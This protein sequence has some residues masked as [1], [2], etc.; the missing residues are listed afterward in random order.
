MYEDHLTA[1]LEEL[2]KPALVNMHT[3]LPDPSPAIRD[4]VRSIAETAHRLIVMAE[5][6]VEI[7][8]RDYGITE[9][10]LVIPHGM[11][12]I[13]PKGR[14]RLK[15]KLGLDG[16][17]IISTF[18]L[19][20]PG[21]GL[22]YAIEAMPA[23]AAR[24]PEALY[25]IAGQTHPELLKQRGE[26]YRNRLQTLVD[27]LGLGDH[28]LFVNQYLDQKDIIEYLLATD[29]YVTPY[30]DPNQITSGT[31]SYAL[32]AGKAVVSTPYLHAKEALAKDRG[33]LVDFRSAESIAEAVN[34]I[35]DDPKRKARLEKNAYAYANEA[36]WPRDRRAVPRRDAGAGRRAS[37]G[38]RA[39]ASRA[40]APDRAPS[41][42]EPA[43]Q[44]ERPRA[45]AAGVRGDL[46]DQ[47]GVA[48][49]R[50]RDR[51]ARPGR[52]ASAPRHRTRR[53]RHDDRPVRS[54]A[55]LDAA[56]PRPPAASSWSAWPTS[57]TTGIPRR[58]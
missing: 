33:I 25:L 52:R 39:Q 58:S 6:A 19:V 32:G 53:R 57:T 55:A 1:F 2:K 8:E 35:L 17:T 18:G 15:A 3:V 5:T 10:P 29:V 36:T 40:S 16:H 23:V 43:D 24:H 27:E 41:D 22:E 51:A 30:L 45:L 26:E 12:H 13:E 50:G 48:Q 14:R 37:R 21:K 20:G 47:P 46:H 44:T 54:S 34:A 38:A 9:H 56:A 31:L 28:V 49:G 42:G 11:P 7:L 4:A